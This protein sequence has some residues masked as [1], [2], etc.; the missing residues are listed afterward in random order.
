METHV[1]VLRINEDI[2]GFWSAMA[3]TPMIIRWV[4]VS[5]AY[6]PWSWMPYGYKYSKCTV[7]E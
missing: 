7:N 6:K 5:Q 1:C 4:L 3:T 2:G